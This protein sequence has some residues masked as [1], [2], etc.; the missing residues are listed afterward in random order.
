MPNPLQLYYAQRVKQ[1]FN[2]LHDFEVNKDEDSLHDLRVEIKKLKALITFLKTVYPR[3]KL[4]KASHEISAVF[5]KA[6]DVREYQ[7]LQGW[8]SR[9]ELSSMEQAFFPRQKLTE[10]SDDFHHHTRSHKQEFKEIIDAV[11]KYVHSVK[12]K[13]AEQYVSGLHAQMEK[14]V[15]TRPEA[16]QWHEL[17]KLIKQWLYAV[18]WVTDAD[19]RRTY[20]N[21][22]QYDKL[23][24]AIGFWHDSEVIRDTLFFKQVYLSNDKAL[25]KDFKKALSAINRSVRYRKKQVGEMLTRIPL[26]AGNGP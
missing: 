16:D 17:R 22:S 13:Q 11:S 8:I 4:K 18:N 5:R 6:G 3:K 15:I 25:L 23:Q 2:N 1:F 10:L 19:S 24:E 7:L 9:H 21:F 26:S 20:P 12:Q 14:I